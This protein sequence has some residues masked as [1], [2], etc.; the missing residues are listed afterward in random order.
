MAAASAIGDESESESA[1]GDESEDD[2]CVLCSVELQEQYEGWVVCS[3][4]GC[5]SRIALTELDLHSCSHTAPD[6]SLQQLDYSQDVQMATALQ[7]REEQQ[8]SV[9]DSDFQ[10]ALSLQQQE[11]ESHPTIPNMSPLSPFLSPPTRPS[12]PTSRKNTIG[13]VTPSTLPFPGPTSSTKYKPTSK[14]H[15]LSDYKSDGAATRGRGTRGRGERGRGGYMEQTINRLDQDVSRGKISSQKYYSQKQDL[16]E[17]MHTGRDDLTSCSEGVIQSL[18]Y[19]YQHFTPPWRFYLSIDTPHF[20]YSLGD[21][22][23]GCGYRNI[24]MLVGSL[25]KSEKYRE[26]MSRIFKGEVPTVPRLQ[27]LLDE[28]WRAGYDPVG[29]RD[30]GFKVRDTRTWIGATETAVLL[31]SCGVKAEVLDFV[32]PTG[33]NGTHI[34]LVE[35]V[36]DFFRASVDRPP[37]YLQYSGH[38][39]TIIGCGQYRSNRYLILLDPKVD[40][41]KLRRCVR[42]RDRELVWMLSRMSSQFKKQQ[43]QIV[44]ID[45]LIE[46]RLRE[47][48]KIIAPFKRFI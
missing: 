7:L 45:G 5:W 34:H 26:P 30:L 9:E 13:Y 19:S 1:I 40:P 22:G 39:Q 11:N 33:L 25:L 21:R 47:A 3:H 24:Q 36:E 44:F 15:T 46:P 18:R 14:V 6:S 29:A 8:F 27:E 23:W 12:N 32:R 41:G 31:R 20:S 43:Y 38:S 2:D 10:I 17:S 48:Y 16:L 37:L 42:E 4:P 35:W 28:A